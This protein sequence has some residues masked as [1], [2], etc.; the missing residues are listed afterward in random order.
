MSTHIIWFHGDIGEALLMSTHNKVICGELTLVMLNKLRW[1]TP[2]SNFQ[3]IRILDPC[4]L[5]RFMY[6]MTNSAD[7]DQLASSE[8]N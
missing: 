6:L 7:P 2:T 4:Y 5:Y 8:A 1:H 3:P